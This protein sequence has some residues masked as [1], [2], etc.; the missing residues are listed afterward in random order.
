MIE[1]GKQRKMKLVEC[2]FEN[3]F[4]CD[5][6]EQLARENQFVQRKSKLNGKTFLS[7]IVFNVNSLHQESLNDLTID[8][9]QNYNVDISKQGL[10]DRFAGLILKLKP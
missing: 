5:E 8:L 9:V 1:L 2:Q 10:H 4:N 3:H 6:I 7:L